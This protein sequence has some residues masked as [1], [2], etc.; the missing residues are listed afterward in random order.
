VAK[1]TFKSGATSQ[2]IDVFIA[3]S[4]STTGAGLSGLV[5]NSSGLKAY[6]RRGATGSA[7]SI[8]LATQ[9]VGGAYSSGGFV[10]IDATNMKGVYR[11]DV[12]DAAFSST[13]WAT[14]YLYGATNMAPCVVELEIV[15]Y[16][17]F[18]G[19]R[20]GLTAIPNGSYGAQIIPLGW[21]GDMS[22]SGTVCLYYNSAYN[23]V[24]TS[25]GSPSFTIT[26]FSGNTTN[27]GLTHTENFNSVTGLNILKVDVASV[28]GSSSLNVF[29]DWAVYLSGG[30]INSNAVAGYC[31]GSLSVENRRT[32]L[33]SDI[34]NYDPGS[35]ETTLQ[36][37]TNTEAYVKQHLPFNPSFGSG[38]TLPFKMVLS[39][40]HS[41]PAT[42]K[43]VTAQISANGGA[44]VNSIN[45]V[46]EIGSGWYVIN[47]DFTELSHTVI[48]LKF[49]ASGTDQVDVTIYPDP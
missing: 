43:T 24:L 41:T 15:S 12:P 29:S 16:N 18:D 38:A 35:G 27:T 40:D 23:D 3:D 19:T 49:T 20:L 46:T 7:T 8:T 13:P 2:T 9:T 31:L 48:A 37:L 45:A 26:D 10:E 25:I 4:S 44:F 17:P 11:L 42:G 28:I 32:V 21:S 34:W 1:R 6:Y 39:S 5:F 33:A 30:S 36:S 47:L 14:L 22:N